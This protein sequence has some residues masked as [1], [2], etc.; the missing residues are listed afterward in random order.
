M[1]RALGR[2]IGTFL[3]K[4]NQGNMEL[5]LGEAGNAMQRQFAGAQGLGAMPGFYG[6]PGQMEMQLL[7]L[8]APYDLSNQQA[9]LA[10]NQMQSNF[11]NQ[12]LG[13]NFEGLF[14]EPS[15]F[16]QFLGPLMNM[17]GMFGGAALGL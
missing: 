13:Q 11:Y 2:E 12:L 14:M 1:N 10:N 3:N 7:G 6:A 5:Q 8:Q 4:E 16:S 9:G 15:Q 17:L